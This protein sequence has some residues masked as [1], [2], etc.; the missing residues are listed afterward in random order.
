M[1][2]MPKHKRVEVETNDAPSLPISSMKSMGKKW[3][4]WIATL[5]FVGSVFAFLGKDM[6]SEALFAD[7]LRILGLGLAASLGGIVGFTFESRKSILKAE[8]SLRQAQ[9]RA[10]DAMA[11]I[12]KQR[13]RVPS[14]LGTESSL[15]RLQNQL[16]QESTGESSLS[17]VD[18][19]NLIDQALT[20]NG[21]S[22]AALSDV[23]SRQ[24]EIYQHHA[25][26]RAQWS[27]LFAVVAMLAGLACVAI[28]GWHVINTKDVT[29]GV[30]LAGI[31]GAMASFL[32]ATF[33]RVYRVSI[34][35]LHIYFQ[36]PVVND[37]ILTAQRLANQIGPEE[38]RHKMYEEI[39]R[40]VLTRI[41]VIGPSPDKKG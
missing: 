36:Q 30:S 29:G 10:Y 15:E 26:S 7:V 41:E 11:G 28:G 3:L 19:R 12:S 4:P 5:C 24:I 17:A 27:F 1:E 37:H 21:K 33:L 38:Q 18:V 20:E 39:I 32:S 34:E 16:A 40:K 23:F 14:T 22:I 9:E 6:V 2:D 35:Q 13:P 31:G 25:R 8:V